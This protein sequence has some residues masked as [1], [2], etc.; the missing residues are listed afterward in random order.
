MFKDSV[1]LFHAFVDLSSIVAVA[2]DCI[3][4]FSNFRMPENLSKDSTITD[5]KVDSFQVGHSTEQAVQW[6][7]EIWIADQIQFLQLESFL[8]ATV[9]VECVHF[10]GHAI[11]VGQPV[12]DLVWNYKSYV[13]Y[14]IDIL[15]FNIVQLS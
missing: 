5:C 13:I 3:F 9:S 1:L 14:L 7:L 12:V 10:A 4:E 11:A 8:K 6:I 2:K 15:P